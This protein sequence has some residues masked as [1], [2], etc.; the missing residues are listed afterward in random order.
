MLA[1][2]LGGLVELARLQ[3]A[4][5]KPGERPEDALGRVKPLVAI[6]ADA[7]HN[8]AA[9]DLFL[10]RARR[11]NVDVLMFGSPAAIS[12]RR[13][14]AEQQGVPV[15]ELPG[16]LSELQ[17]ALERLGAPER[18][19]RVV[20]RRARADRGQDGTLI[21]DDG[22]GTRWS[23]YDRRAGDRRRAEVDRRFVSESGEVLHCGVSEEEAAATS[24]AALAEQLARA[25]PL[26]Q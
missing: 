16:Q 3:A 6:L 7:T 4:F 20:S 23:V 8:E 17:S 14:W 19:P 22:K 5:A 18:K 15:F 13:E 25:T 21:F 11:R 10:A 2:L 12:Q 1:A 26:A 9:S 24:V